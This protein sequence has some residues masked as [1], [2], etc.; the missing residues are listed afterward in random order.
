MIKV[1]ADG[2]DGG[3]VLPVSEE[4]PTTERVRGPVR[5]PHTSVGTFVGDQSL[6][7]PVAGQVALAKPEPAL[8]V[9][10][11]PTPVS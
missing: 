6:L 4:T 7:G 5:T 10:Q 1:R 8:P 11:Q 2:A 3:S 9:L